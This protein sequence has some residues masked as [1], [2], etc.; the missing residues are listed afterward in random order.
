MKKLN[1]FSSKTV[2]RNDLLNSFSVF[3]IVAITLFALFMVYGTLAPYQSHTH[4][5]VSELSELIAK[6]GY[7]YCF[8]VNDADVFPL[9]VPFI[10][11]ICQFAFL[12]QKDN[13]YTLLSFGVKRERL[14]NNRVA[15]PLI[16]MLIITLVI[17]GIALG[18]NI[19]YLYFSTEILKAWL[20]H[21]LI[22]LQMIVYIYSITVFCCHMC[23]R[24]VEAIGASVSLIGLPFVLSYFIKYLMAFSLYGFSYFSDN[25]LSDAIN[26]INPI[27]FEDYV[28]SIEDYSMTLGVDLNTRAIASLVWLIAS[29]AL[30]AYTKKYFAKKYKPEI[31]G[32]KGAKTGMVYV[33]SITAPMLLAYVALDNVKNYYYPLVT[34]RVK[35]MAFVAVIIMGVLG[36]IICNLAI[37]LTFKRIKIALVAGFSIGAVAGITILIGFTGIFGTYDKLPEIADIENVYI[38][39]PFDNYILKSGY[40]A[41]LDSVD[42]YV[43]DD[44]YISSKEDIKLVLDIHNQILNDREA[45]SVSAI[46]IRYNLKNGTTFERE[47]ANISNSA[48]E[49]S[50]QLWESD[51][52]RELVKGHIIPEK[53]F[54]PNPDYELEGNVHTSFTEESSIEIRSKYNVTCDVAKQLTAEQS[55]QL[56][57]AA[58]KDVLAMN[59]EE[60]FRP[61]A[62]LLGTISF[63]TVTDKPLG[64]NG[65][66]YSNCCSYVVP[67]Y[68]TM[69]NTLS[70]SPSF[71][72]SFRIKASP[73]PS[74]KSV[75]RM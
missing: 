21:I 32:F 40:Y 11:A 45:E 15:L 58:Q 34:A 74:S 68:E 36:A 31:S 63:V 14:Y 16:A 8:T 2:A 7:K 60:W 71:D 30:L 53:T 57:D 64:Y 51:A 54:K 22:Y 39:A 6:G 72:K 9:A 41:R 35:I 17:K 44:I 66:Y 48:I 70:S 50:L 5:I 49:K 28:N 59:Y 25:L 47:Y 33:I 1:E 55:F 61:T 42:S 20:I 19:H 56:R 38:S 65:Y 12:H 67:V 52:V 37:H 3:T 69:A 26:F 13:C 43:D 23:G 73:S 24:T 4:T 10:V 75:T 29:I 46:C 18:I 27:P 62:K